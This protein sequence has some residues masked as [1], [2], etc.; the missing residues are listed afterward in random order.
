M[1]TKRSANLKGVFVLMLVGALSMATVAQA[2]FQIVPIFPILRII[3]VNTYTLTD[4]GVNTPDTTWSFGQ[5][6][7]NSGEAVGEFDVMD[8]TGAQRGFRTMANQAFLPG[9]SDEFG[10]LAGDS[11]SAAFAI[12]AS[13]VVIGDSSNG[14]VAWSDATGSPMHAFRSRSRGI[15][16]ES[17]GPTYYADRLY[18]R[19]IDFA[20]R[21]VG[22]FKNI[23]SDFPH[24]MFSSCGPSCIFPLDFPLNFPTKSEAYGINSKVQIVGW[25]E[26]SRLTAFMLQS[27]GTSWL[28]TDIGFPGSDWSKAFAINDNSQVVG[29]SVLGGRTHHAFLFQDINSNGVQDA[30]E[31]RDLDT[32]NSIRSGA[33]S[34][35][36]G[37]TAVGYQSGDPSVGGDSHA[38]IF[39]P[40]GPMV[41]LNVLVPAGTGRWT[42]RLASG[43]NDNGQIAGFMEDKTEIN[44]L[45]RARHAFRLDVA[46]SIWLQW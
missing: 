4:L 41:D 38:S 23:G 12:N 25:R 10:P 37:G 2:Q 22:S 35:N 46:G 5:G 45:R 8:G 29:E 6:I 1:K 44:P 34:I 28:A 24:A 26:T 11:R 17:Y 15:L 7:N 9:T 3:R 43:I 18:A 19:G 33:R 14:F 42:L 40:N 32:W 21:V 16:L 27:L 20:G 39:I 30:N 13:G 36:A 31:I